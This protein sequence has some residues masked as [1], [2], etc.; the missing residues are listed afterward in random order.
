MHWWKSCGGPSWCWQYSRSLLRSEIG[1]KEQNCICELTKVLVK[2]SAGLSDWRWFILE[3]FILERRHQARVDLIWSNFLN[4]Q[5]IPWSW[6]CADV[7]CLWKFTAATKLHLMCRCIL[8][9]HK[10]QKLTDA[11]EVE[12]LVKLFACVQVWYSHVI[13]VVNSW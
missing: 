2:W 13:P 4:V 1:F 5:W 7:S 6:H 10:T 8:Y 9:V 3:C 12:W 11:F